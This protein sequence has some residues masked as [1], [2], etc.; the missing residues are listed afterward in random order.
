MDIFLIPKDFIVHQVH[1]LTRNDFK[2]AVPHKASAYTKIRYAE[3]IGF[4]CKG[5]ALSIPHR[6]HKHVPTK[7][8]FFRTNNQ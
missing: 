4:C 7:Y 1:P 6:V 3:T 2:P 8:I 5:R